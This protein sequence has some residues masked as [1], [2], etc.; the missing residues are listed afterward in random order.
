M[1]GV[2]SREGVRF[3]IMF[4][5]QQLKL[6]PTIQ[7]EQKGLPSCC[8]CSLRQ[9]SRPTICVSGVLFAGLVINR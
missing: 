4:E 2:S 1:N 3:S 6:V 9:Q 7:F 5:G 8:S